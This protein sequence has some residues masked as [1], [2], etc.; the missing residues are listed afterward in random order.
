MD[1]SEDFIRLAQEKAILSEGGPRFVV[2]DMGKLDLKESSDAIISMSGAF[3]YIPR[4]EG[5]GVLK[6]FAE[7]LTEGGLLI[8]EFWNRLAI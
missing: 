2:G 1:L 7:K 6:G 8:F 5:P 4:L 3:G